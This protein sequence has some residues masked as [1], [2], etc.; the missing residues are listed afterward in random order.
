M[1]TV[2]F[3]AANRDGGINNA[4][5]YLSNLDRIQTNESR[6]SRLGYSDNLNQIRNGKSK[7]KVLKNVNGNDI[8]FNT[9]MNSDNGQIVKRMKDTKQKQNCDDKKMDRK[10]KRKLSPSMSCDNEEDIE[11]P[12]KKRRKMRAR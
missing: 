10:K 7:N 3:K 12:S 4:V 1:L 8:R 2:S 9:K 5:D 11:S 6:M